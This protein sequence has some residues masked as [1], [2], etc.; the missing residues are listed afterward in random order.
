MSNLEEFIKMNTRRTSVV[1]VGGFRP[2]GDPL[3]TNFCLRPVALPDESWPLH[4]GEPLYFICQ[5][6][7]TQAPFVPEILQDIAVITFFIKPEL[8]LMSESNGNDWCVRAYK[9]L[10]GLE[11][12]PMPEEM[13]EWERGFE[14]QWKEV[15]DQPVYDDPELIV[16][17]GFDA[18]E[19]E[20]D[21]VG[22]TK[23]GG[24][25]SNI[26]SEPWWGYR[27]HPAKPRYCFQ[28]DSEEKVNLMWGDNGRIYIARGTTPGTEDEWFLEWQC[29]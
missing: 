29:Y 2:T 5:L 1:H 21:N 12:M 26:Q 13:P 10:D 27:A 7:L 3:A 11:P 9:S 15:E 25:A 24:Y 16:P 18:D 6:N 22:M 20:L 23:I 4:E 14:C 8:G 17:E 28:I 19:I